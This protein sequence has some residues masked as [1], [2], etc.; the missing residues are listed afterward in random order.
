MISFY[1]V[2]NAGGRKYNEDC[3][4]VLVEDTRW[5]CILADGLGGMGGGAD[6]AQIVT[7]TLKE[8]FDSGFMTSQTLQ[9]CC[10]RA[11]QAVQQKKKTLGKHGSL[12]STVVLVYGTE[13]K[14]HWIYCGDS[15]FYLFCNDAIC[16]RTKDHSVPQM[17]ASCG[18][19]R[20]EE[21]RCHPDRNRLL[22]CLG[23]EDEQAK[24]SA[25][26]EMDIQSG[27]VGLLCSDGFWEPVSEVQMLQEHCR[28]KSVQQ[29]IRALV[30]L[31][32]KQPKDEHMDNFSAI[33]IWVH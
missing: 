22:A 18:E 29:W 20:E 33:G 32:R 3:V 16:H 25:V 28:A 17:L 7:Q 27:L 10:Q 26:G 15:R 13:K 21:I 12:F 19:I 11:H 24:L 8:C 1:A 30:K 31:V 9:E 5:C 2:T 23:T 6:A 4:E 14:M